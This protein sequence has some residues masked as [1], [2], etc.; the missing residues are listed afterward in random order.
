VVALGAAALSP[1]AAVLIPGFYMLA[2]TR[3]QRRERA[4]DAS[5]AQLHEPRARRRPWRQR[6]TH[7]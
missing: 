3:E 2:V 5:C 4:I 7:R 6:A 1:S